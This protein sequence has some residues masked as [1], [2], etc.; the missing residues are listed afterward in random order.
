MPGLVFLGDVAVRDIPNIV[1]EVFIDIE[2]QIIN[3]YSC[4]K[5]IL[6]IID[7]LYTVVIDRTCDD[8]LIEHTSDMEFP[9]A[10]VSWVIRREVNTCHLHDD[11]ETFGVEFLL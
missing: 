1:D 8:V 9:A 4:S 7:V 11:L 5:E 3:E 2:G 6:S 10:R